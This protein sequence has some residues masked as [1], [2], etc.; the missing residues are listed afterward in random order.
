MRLAIDVMGGD[1][2]P[3]AILK[4]CVEALDHIQADDELVLVGPRPVIEAF[5]E[6]HGVG[7]PRLSIEHA[8]QVI[9]MHDSPA[10]AVRS[11]TD[12]SIVR[13]ARSNWLMP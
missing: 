4:G 10:K 7:D 3:D 11:K 6:E 2:A 9:E 5:L 13:M 12:S 1:H 8:E